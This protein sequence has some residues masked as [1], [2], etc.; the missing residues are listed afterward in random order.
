MKYAYLILAVVGLVLSGCGGGTAEEDTMALDEGAASVDENNKT[1]TIALGTDIVTFDIH[2][3]NNTS[4]EAVHDNMFNYL[5]KR[6]EN[7]VIQPELVDTFT[8]IDDVT[9]EM[10][11][12]EGVTFHNGDTLTAED[13]K[14]TL[15]RV[16]TDETLQEYPNYRQIKEVDTIDERTFQIITHEPEPSLLHRLSRL[17][18]GILPKR[19]IEEEGWDHFLA[20]P[21]GTGPYEFKEWVRDSRIV[22]TPYDDYFEGP[23]EEWDEVVFRIIPE[24]STRVSELLTGGVDI[25]VNIPPADWDR[26]N[27][28]AGTAMKSETSNRTMMLILRAT[29][30]YPTADVRVRKALNLAIDNG[31]ITDSALRGAGTPT[32]TRVAPGNFGAEESLYDTYDYDPEEAKRLL[33]E[34][35]YGDGFEMTLHSPRGRYLQDAEIAELIGGMLQAINVSVNVELMEWS[36]FVEMRQAGANK[37]AYLIGLGNSMFDGA[38][39]VDW[40]RSDRFVGQTDYKNKEI[41]ALLE[42]SAVN[43]DQTER[44]EQLKEIQRIADEELPHIML[45]QETVNYGVNDRIDFVPKMDEMIYAPEIKRK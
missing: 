2:D 12:K 26:V 7:N 27:G 42:A 30:G 24:N 39:S 40:Y 35:G 45:H 23:V 5:F 10:T 25:A 29:D 20:H 4:T 22:L 44:A 38:Y 16:A 34:A 37:D 41:D 32:K 11:L 36:N 15:E 9:V 6:D 18:S 8:Q 21:I 31:A 19:Y 17:G 3:H 43:M 14:F 28:N 1:L 33:E 13:V